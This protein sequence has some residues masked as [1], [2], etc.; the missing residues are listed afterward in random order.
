MFGTKLSLL[1]P[2][3]VSHRPN[4]ERLSQTFPILEP[5]SVGES[6]FPRYFGTPSSPAP[7]PPPNPPLNPLTQVLGS[8]AL[9][10]PESL[11][12]TDRRLRHRSAMQ[13]T[14]AQFQ[15]QNQS[16][17]DSGT[18]A[19]AVRGPSLSAEQRMLLLLKGLEG[20][21]DEVRPP[22]GRRLALRP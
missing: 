11:R 6:S 17:A 8:E 21:Q 18:S 22:A 10:L 12:T 9:R 13:R 15:P 3:R 2:M 4:T 19:L 14:L 7:N 20:L 5:L 16:V 1:N